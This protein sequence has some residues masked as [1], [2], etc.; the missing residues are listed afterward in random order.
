LSREEGAGVPYLFDA[1]KSIATIKD[2]SQ[3][4]IERRKKKKVSNSIE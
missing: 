4:P 2:I 1:V 3:P